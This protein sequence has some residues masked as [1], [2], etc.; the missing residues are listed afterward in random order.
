[1]RGIKTKKPLDLRGFRLA[2]LTRLEL[3]TSCVTGRHSNQT[4]LQHQRFVLSTDLLLL[5]TGA[6]IRPF[7]ISA[8]F[9]SKKN[10]FF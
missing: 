8:S 5:I 7:F 6:K 4:E 3:A 2:V 10:H 1:M 9:F